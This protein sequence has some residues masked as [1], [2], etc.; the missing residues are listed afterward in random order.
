MY[1]VTLIVLN[2]NDYNNYSIEKKI[3]LNFWIIN[4]YLATH[5]CTLNQSYKLQKKK[6]SPKKKSFDCH[7]IHVLFS[8]TNFYKYTH[9]VA[10]HLFV[11]ITYTAVNWHLPIELMK[12]RET[13][14]SET[15]DNIFL[16]CICICMCILTV[17]CQN[18]FALKSKNKISVCRKFSFQSWYCCW[19]YFWTK[20]VF[21]KRLCD[22]QQPAIQKE[23]PWKHHLNIWRMNR[24]KVMP[25]KAP[26]PK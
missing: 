24:T 15:L 16:S 6:K 14:W 26:Q 22:R 2:W 19:N 10:L 25:Q 1:Y 3:N 13:T 12:T 20:N 21:G 9:C 7:Y 5:S 18:L 11:C 17:D 8:C 4:K 23:S